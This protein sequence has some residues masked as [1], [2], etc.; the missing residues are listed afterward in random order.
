[1]REDITTN[2]TEIQ[3]IRRDYMNNY[4]STG[5]ITWKKWIHTKKQTTYQA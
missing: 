5:W 1:M 2:T 3:R 4:L